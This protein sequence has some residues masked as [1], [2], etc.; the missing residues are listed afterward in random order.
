MKDK[1]KT[2]LYYVFTLGI[3]YAIAKNKAK[4]LAK[5]V[6]SEIK[7]NE[8]IDFN[9]DELIT[10]LGGLENISSVSSTL[11]CLIVE[12]K[13]KTLIE[14]NNFNKFITKGVFLTNNK[15]NLIFGDNSKYIC[16]LINN[17]L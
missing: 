17:K 13:D 5:Q 10:E 12:L 9:I 15:L 7:V 16:T 4:K 2:R 6:N 1:T 11:S 14:I 3:G 8:N